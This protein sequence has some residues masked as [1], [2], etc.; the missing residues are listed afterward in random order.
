MRGGGGPGGAC[1]PGASHSIIGMLAL[2]TYN[3]NYVKLLTS[4]A[5]DLI[6]LKSSG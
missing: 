4:Q 3:V 6:A 5:V 1:L 2:I